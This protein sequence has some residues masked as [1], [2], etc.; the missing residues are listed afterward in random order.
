MASASSSSSMLRKENHKHEVL[1]EIRNHEI[2][3]GELNSLSASSVVYQKIG[4][5][6]F[7]KSIESA[8]TFE[9]KKLEAEKAQ[10][11]KLDKTS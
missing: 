10:L 6:Y 8:K 3:I 11:Q 4:N 5:I 9:E 7:R 1:K 2:A